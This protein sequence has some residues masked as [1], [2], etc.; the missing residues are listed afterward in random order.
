MRTVA[1]PEHWEGKKQGYRIENLGVGR[2]VSTGGQEGL[3][4]EEE[5]TTLSTQEEGSG[6]IQRIAECKGYIVRKAQR[7]KRKKGWSGVTAVG[8]R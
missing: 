1:S 2:T 6:R 5:L 3:K 7:L 4:P 8:G